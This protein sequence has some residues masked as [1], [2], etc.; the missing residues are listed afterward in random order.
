M[1]SFHKIGDK[2]RPGSVWKRGKVGG[3][4]KGW[5]CRG[6]NDPNNVCTYEYINKEKKERMGS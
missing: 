6:V 1:F 5:G 4:G 2:G 3:R